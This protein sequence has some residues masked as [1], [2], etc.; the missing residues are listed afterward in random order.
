MTRNIYI[1]R[2]GE[3]LASQR[4]A[5][6]SEMDPI[7]VPLTAWGN[8]Q[9]YSAGKWL[10][11]NAEPPPKKLRVYYSPHFRIV[12][13]KDAFVSGFGRDAC[14]LIQENALLEERDHGD[15][16][17]LHP[18]KQ[19]ELNPEAYALLEHG[20]EEEK[21]LT[22]MPKGESIADVTKRMQRFI[23]EVIKSA[24]KDEDIII[25]SHGGNCRLLEQLLT[26]DTKY[27]PE[28]EH[29][30]DYADIIKIKDDNSNEV[31]FSTEQRAKHNPF[32]SYTHYL[33]L[34]PK[35]G[36]IQR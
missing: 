21:Y 20:T 8:K 18:N 26:H 36:C 34:P 19:K 12:Q 16:N 3:S 7:A 2:H 24:P 23:D 15:F 13:S 22:P 27:P 25:I 35:G 31:V 9:V 17:G 10:R 29:A 14:S 33:A 5:I 28:F 11:E 30:Q 4:R 6:F 1:L 32:M